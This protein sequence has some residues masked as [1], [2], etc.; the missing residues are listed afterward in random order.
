MEV[1]FGEVNV[2]PD[3][4][5]NSVTVISSRYIVDLE[6]LRYAASKAM[7]NWEK[8]MRI[9]KSPAL[10][11]L[12]YYSATRQIRDAIKIAARGREKA[13]LVVLDEEEFEDVKDE[14]E[15]RELEFAPDYDL[16][17]IKAV[18]GITDEEI[19]ITGIE[20]LALLIRERIALF[21]VSRDVR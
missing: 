6:N 7:E 8:G 10:E 15:F 18:Y 3:F 21:S 14:I 16:E 5:S 20:K 9:S 13:G 2:K 17:E 11:V 12:L 1:L 4:R 19:E